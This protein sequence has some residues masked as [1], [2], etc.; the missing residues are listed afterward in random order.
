MLLA[1]IL[2]AEI[3]ATVDD[4]LVTVIVKGAPADGVLRALASAAGGTVRREQGVWLL[5]PPTLASR[6]FARRYAPKKS[7][8][9][10]LDGVAADDATELV[11]AV[12]PLPKGVCAGG[13]AKM[14]A[15]LRRAPLAL[16]R[17]ALFREVG[18]VGPWCATPEWGGSK[19]DSR[20]RVT[21]V[22]RSGGRAAVLVSGN[23]PPMLLR[24]DASRAKIVIGPTS[25]G[26]TTKD[27]RWEAAV[28]SPELPAEVAGTRDFVGSWRLA[29]T[30]RDGAIWRALLVGDAGAVWVS[31][32]ETDRVLSIEPGA[33]VLPPERPGE[34]PITLRLRRL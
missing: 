7:I 21:G 18:M 3:I 32:T 17:D 27:W 5:E 8:E 11:R 13:F 1:E 22:A 14:S 6:P 2:G 26:I 28:A 12:A 15:R 33:V 16:V 9:L 25:V 31:S 19:P 29:A 23:G 20:L 34:K 4:R 24:P 10:W 30:L